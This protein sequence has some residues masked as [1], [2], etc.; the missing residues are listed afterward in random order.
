MSE[1]ILKGAIPTESESRGVI[2]ADSLYFSSNTNIYRIENSK[3]KMLA[4][5]DGTIRLF[6]INNNNVFIATENRVYLN[7]FEHCIGSLKRS[8]T[9][10]DCNDDYLVIGVN[11][12]LEVWNIPKEYK[13]TL[14]K[15]HSRLVGH[16]RAIK[17]IKIVD[18]DRIITA[19][20][21]LSVRL[22]DISKNSS[23][24]IASLDSTPTGLH[25]CQN[26]CIVSCKNGSVFFIDLDED[27]L[28]VDFKN[29]KFEGTILCSSS[30]GDF[31]AIALTGI[32]VTDTSGMEN[33]VLLPGDKKEDPKKIELSQNSTIIILKNMEEIFKFDID[34]LA[35]EISLKGL[36]LA[37]KTKNF[38]GIFDI[39]S[40]NFSLGID[41]PKIVSISGGKD[42][43]SAGCDDRIIRIYKDN[44]CIA[45]LFDDKATGVILN[46]LITSNT[47]IAVYKTGHISAFNITDKSCYRSFS[48]EREL[49]YYSSSQVSED[50]CFLFVSDLSSIYV[51]HL[52]KSRLVDTIKVKSA[53]L[54]LVWYKDFLYSLEINQVLVRHSIFSGLS[55]EMSLE[56]LPTSMMARND[57]IMVSTS[58]EMIVYDLDLNFLTSFRILL[59]G[60]NRSE[61]YSKPKN[62]EHFDFNSKYVF[63][64]GQANK[65]KVIK[66]SVEPKKTLMENSVTQEILVSRNKSWENYKTKLSREKTTE[67]D[68]TKFIEVLKIVSF[69]KKFFVLSREGVKMYEID[70]KIFNPIEFSIETTPEYAIA[71]LESGEYLKA[72]I[73]S[74]QLRDSDL[75]KKVVDQCID[76]DFIIKYI[77]KHYVADL[78]DFIMMYASADSTNLK[79][80]DFINRI[81]YYHEIT[82]SNLYE[83]L[84]RGITEDYRLLRDNCFLLKSAIKNEDKTD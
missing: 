52:Q 18:P 65:I 30:C 46:T 51:I 11:N 26:K 62:I 59:E 47:C 5:C 31:V 20:D 38:V 83:K 50:G 70:H 79:L 42:I 77:P 80:F 57:K 64:G 66:Y 71:M 45:K 29:V 19:S 36:Q 75:V 7:Y 27:K 41:L 49:H 14:F 24:I 32:P 25:L 3:S 15:I 73:S 72:L 9:A 28:S 74:L 43:I 12:I 8:A 56:Q 13:F 21:D 37:V 4:S 69:E 16:Y 1:F 78:V 76:V 2:F 48:L 54:S 68:R 34:Y 33:K 39:Q 55:V 22:F 58:S 6:C 81:V 67:F 23:K 40:E 35:D 10:I 53:I 84:N 82:V 17:Y 63:C 44:Y 61:M 60:R